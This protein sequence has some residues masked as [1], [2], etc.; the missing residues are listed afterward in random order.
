[1][2]VIL[3]RKPNSMVNQRVLELLLR[4]WDGL[5]REGLYGT[6]AGKS[7]G[8]MVFEAL[9]AVKLAPNQAV[10]ALNALLGKTRNSRVRGVIALALGKTDSPTAVPVVLELFHKDGNIASWSAADALLDLKART[11]IPELLDG[12]DNPTTAPGLK[13][14]IL[15]VLGRLGTDEAR[16]LVLPGLAHPNAKVKAQAINLLWLLAPVENSESILWEKLGFSRAGVEHDRPPAWGSEHLQQRLVIALGRCGS[17][18]A[19]PHLERLAAE[20]GRRRSAKTKESQL[21]REALTRNIARA[22]MDLRRK[23]LR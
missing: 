17:P 15:Y 9:A 12:F 8:A 1:M 13:Q 3:G 21:N 7:G 19:I 14:R 6:K 16:R 5:Q 4:K 10:E 18:D 2:Q 11:I 22:E 23:E 20:V